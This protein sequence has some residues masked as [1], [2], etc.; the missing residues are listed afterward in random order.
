MDTRHQYDLL[1]DKYLPVAI[2]V[3]VAVSGA[4][5]VLVLR[6]RRR[7][8]PSMRKNN[9]P[10][11]LGYAGVLVV[12]VGLLLLWTFRT[13]RRIDE[14]QARPVERVLVLGARWHWRFTYPRYGIVI[15]GSEERP[16][17]TPTLVVPAGQPVAFEA[18]SADVIH[19]FWI[20]ALRFQRQLFDDRITRFTLVFR[21]DADG[22]AA[23]CSFYCG[24]L[25][26][27]MRFRVH[28]VSPAAYR[29]WARKRGARA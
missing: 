3:Y 17:R 27:Q 13:E 29:A 4:I 26:A 7:G 23:P 25:H 14:P 20:P 24:L 10:L 1:A 11:E 16:A 8:S 12:T 2:A 21:E 5:L 9:V 19:G 15:Q 28:V 6:G 18:R 22:N